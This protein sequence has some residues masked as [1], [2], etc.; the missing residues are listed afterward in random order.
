MRLP[1]TAFRFDSMR[2]NRFV[3]ATPNHGY[4]MIGVGE[5]LVAQTIGTKPGCSTSLL[6]LRRGDLHPVSN[7]PVELNNYF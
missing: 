2:E 3:I 7:S 5:K 4:K 6:T 1:R